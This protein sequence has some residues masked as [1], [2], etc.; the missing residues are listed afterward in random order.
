M[1]GAIIQPSQLENT[2]GLIQ[3]PQSNQIVGWWCL[4]NILNL[5]IEETLLSKL[6]CKL[7]SHKK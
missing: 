3:Y 7:Q 5:V 2:D 6:H 4:P 1:N